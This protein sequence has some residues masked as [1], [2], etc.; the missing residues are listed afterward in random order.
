VAQTR[1]PVPVDADTEHQRHRRSHRVAVASLVVGAVALLAVPVGIFD[2]LGWR[3]GGGP[4]PAGTTAGADS[5]AGTPSGRA[6]P[7]PTAATAAFKYLSTLPPDNAGALD[8]LPGNLVAA[9]HPRA[10][11]IRCPAKGSVTEI[12]YDLLGDYAS[13]SAQVFTDTRTRV[14]ADVTA[15]AITQNR[16]GTTV[17]RQLGRTTVSPTADGKL[18]GDVRGIMRLIVQVDCDT[19]DGHVVVD[20]GRL[21]LA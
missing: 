6:T 19:S 8:A 1:Q 15:F 11:T 5:T 20:D 13:F 4:A 12:G 21:T 16:D 18:T 2:W 14:L 9:E 3:P 7:S 10:L 17:K